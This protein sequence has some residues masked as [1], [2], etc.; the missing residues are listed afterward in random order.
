MW[1]ALQQK[2]YKIDYE[3]RCV[4]V[5]SKIEMGCSAVLAPT[6]RGRWGKS[7]HSAALAP[8]LHL[9]SAHLTSA[10]H[11]DHLKDLTWKAA[12]P[13][14]HIQYT[15]QIDHKDFKWNKNSAFHPI[16]MGPSRKGKLQNTK[17]RI[18]PC[19]LHLKKS[20]KRLKFAFLDQKYLLFGGIFP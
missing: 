3:K 9:T 5:Y 12:A 19:P 18:P 16:R 11:T 10:A 6:A 14:L 20:Q 13:L 2:W 4:K 7:A 1:T 15:T 8:I 17:K